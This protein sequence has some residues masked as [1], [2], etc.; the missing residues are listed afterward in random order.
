MYPFPLNKIKDGAGGVRWEGVFLYGIFIA[1][2]LIACVVVLHYYTKKKGM[3]S[4][5]QD[6]L[7]GVGIIA[8]ALGFLAAKLFQAFYDYLANP[9]AGF[10]FVGAGI[11]VM[12]G[13]VGG[14]IAFLLA[15]FVGGALYFKGKRRGEHVKHF[16]TIVLV[17][18]ICICIAH[19][20][21]RLGCLSAGC[22]YGR[23]LSSEYVFGG[24]K[25][26]SSRYNSIP[27]TGYYIPAQLYEA[28]F[29]FLLFGVLSVLYF[30]GFN[31]TMHV[32]LIAYGIWRFIIEIFREDYVGGG[33]DALF[34]PSQVMSFL[35][36]AG[37]I[38]LFIVYLC[39]KIPLRKTN[40]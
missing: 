10:N 1:L 19:A 9:Q 23:F 29:L 27:Q 25:L 35:F 15:Y 40:K 14:A 38:A 28:L 8:V 3:P 33:A 31:I 17:A 20:F 5:V 21:G 24:I 7:Y 26:I 34:R 32:Y 13:L 30:K 4:Y 12:G 16:H 39:L 36:V 11:T 6:F 37:G 22:C 2:G 18:P